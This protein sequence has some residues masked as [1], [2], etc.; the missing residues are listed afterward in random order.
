MTKSISTYR[1]NYTVLIISTWGVTLQV[2]YHTRQIRNN[3]STHRNNS[4]NNKG[5][6]IVGKISYKIDKEQLVVS[7]LF[8]LLDSVKMQLGISD[9]GIKRTTLEDGNH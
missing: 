2:R 8:S 3:I 7:E 9:W 6:Y 5:V 4:F 1:N